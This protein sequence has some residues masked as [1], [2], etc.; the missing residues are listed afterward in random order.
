MLRITV[1]PGV[2]ILNNITGSNVALDIHEASLCAAPRITV[3]FQMQ[4][5]I[6][7]QKALIYQWVIVVN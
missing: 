7:F 4:S 5:E 6:R 1:H 2:S 3:N